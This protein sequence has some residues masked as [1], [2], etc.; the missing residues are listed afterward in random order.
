MSSR[1]SDPL[2]DTMIR[3][4]LRPIA[5]ASPPKGAWRRIVMEIETG[6]QPRH[7]GF[8]SW[9]KALEGFSISPLTQRHCV[10][11]Y[12]RCLPTP[13]TEAVVIQFRGQRLAS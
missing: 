4:A 11:P 12:G 3:Q 10:G 9:F 1:K 8:A 7:R 13:F 2:I 6:T 5:E